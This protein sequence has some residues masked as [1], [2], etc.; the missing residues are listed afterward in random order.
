MLKQEIIPGILALLAALSA[1]IGSVVRQRSAH[2]VTEG[3]VGHL[4]LF[5]M[6]V[7]NR[8]W[9]MGGLG[10]VASYIF[11]AIALDYGSVMLVTCLQVT[12]L[13]FAMPIYARVT[14]HPITR[15]EWVWAVV[16][17]AALALLI[18]VGDP[19]AGEK[20]GAVGD[21]LI[22]AM[23]MGPALVLCVLGAR[24]LKGRPA[25]AV[26]LGA[27]SGSSLALFVVLT[28]GI[29]Q[30]IHHGGHH[31]LHT[32]EFPVW[33]LAGVS[34]MIFQQSAFRAGSLTAS[35]P[36]I[37]VAKPIVAVIL[38]IA[39]LKESL[40]LESGPEW[41]LLLAITVLVIVSTVMLAR[42]EAATIV[43]DEEHAAPVTDEPDKVP[44]EPV[45]D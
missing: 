41:A 26:L 44:S 35:L 17:A 39:V 28:K 1:A 5:S 34:G 10:D 36:T 24:I 2:T 25:S 45:S 43:E 15:S 31:L 3:E 21:W 8:R 9:W 37:T 33:I 30:V 12:V 42:G 38:G 29:T 20:R 22:V 40:Q 4:T 13:L 32:W 11:I 19:T 6:L 27:V 18:K 23:V 14:N 16:L 7:R